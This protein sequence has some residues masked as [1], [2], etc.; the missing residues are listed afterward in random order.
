METNKSPGFFKAVD[1]LMERFCV[2]DYA[3]VA[4]GVDGEMRSNWIAGTGV[5]LISDRER[6]MVL[7]GELAL[8]QHAIIGRHLGYAIM[9]PQKPLP[10]A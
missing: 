4:R 9:P 3:L 7:H 10:D 5:D 2:A 6:A 8:L 1:D